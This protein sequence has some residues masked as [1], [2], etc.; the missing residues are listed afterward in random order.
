M[1]RV[2]EVLQMKHEAKYE[3]TGG[4]DGAA[5]EVTPGGRSRAA[6]PTAILLGFS[7]PWI[8]QPAYP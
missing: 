4:K 7:V 5:V 6:L 2:T 3:V 8:P 1:P